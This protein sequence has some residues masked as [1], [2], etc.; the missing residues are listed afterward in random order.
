MSS[1]GEE[2]TAQYTKL[3]FVVTIEDGKSSGACEGA[4]LDGP[5]LTSWIEFDRNSEFAAATG[6]PRQTDI[7]D[8]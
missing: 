2:A 4:D 5:N 7:Y 3:L 8:F 6:R 1:L